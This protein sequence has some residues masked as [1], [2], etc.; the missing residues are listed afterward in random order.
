[1]TKYGSGKAVNFA[2][3]FIK[4]PTHTTMD[5]SGQTITGSLQII[6]TIDKEVAADISF[7]DANFQAV[8]TS[9]SGKVFGSIGTYT[10]GTLGSGFKTTLGITGAQM[11]TMLQTAVNT[12]ITTL[13]ADLKAGVVIP[14]ILGIK[15]NNVEVNFFKGYVEAGITLSQSVWAQIADAM[16]KFKMYKLS[17]VHKTHKK[18][19]GFIARK[20]HSMKKWFK[21]SY[22]Y[23]EN[24]AEA[25]YDDFMTD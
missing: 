11:L 20:F 13:N 8:I 5:T 15:V 9:H 17:L 19:R 3:N 25:V 22:K 14:S 16:Y 21:K 7:E 4:A 2:G 18:H 6:C 23:M 10:I 1:L 24:E 12:G